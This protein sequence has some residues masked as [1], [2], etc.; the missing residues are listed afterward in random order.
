LDLEEYPPVP[1]WL[2]QVAQAFVPAATLTNIL[3]AFKAVKSFFASPARD[4]AAETRQ[5]WTMW[6]WKLITKN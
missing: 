1:D 2:T 6:W 3:Q 5:V 4:R